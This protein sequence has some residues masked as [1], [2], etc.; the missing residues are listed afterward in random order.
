MT[1]KFIEAPNGNL[2]IDNA[3]II[4]RNFIGAQSQYNRLG[5]RNFNWLIED[6]AV[7]D[8]LSEKGW[9]VKIK[10]PRE[11]GDSPFMHLKVNVNFNGRGPHIYL[12]SNGNMTKL[13]EESV[14]RLDKINIDYVDMDIRPYHWTQKGKN[15]EVIEEGI[16]AYLQSMRVVQET[17]RFAD[18]YENIVS[19]KDLETEEPDFIDEMFED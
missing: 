9:N 15:G 19:G 6:E 14:E 7:A 1:M 18:Y 13:D 5:D 2:Q 3:Q 11:K 17:D 8:Y 4:Y 10:P 16:S 12:E